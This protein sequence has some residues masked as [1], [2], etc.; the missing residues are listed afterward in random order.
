MTYLELVQKVARDSGTEGIVPASVTGLT[1]RAGDIAVWVNDAYRKIQTSR[2][3]WLFKEKTFSGQTLSG[4]QS[5]NAAAM[6]ISGPFREWIVSE[7]SNRAREFGIYRTSEGISARQSLHFIPWSDF[8]EN[9]L[10]DTAST[11]LP[12]FISISPERHL[13]LSSVPDGIYTITGHYRAGIHVLTANDDE[14][15][16]PEEFHDLVAYEALVFLHNYD[17]AMNQLPFAEN[18][19]RDMMGDLIASQT[20]PVFITGAMT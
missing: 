15:D 7:N 12:I 18:R 4:V 16:F 20:G 5:Y 2:S 11:G 14:P 9:R 17:E 8:R 6:G 3:D 1:G 19:R 13:Y 10:Y